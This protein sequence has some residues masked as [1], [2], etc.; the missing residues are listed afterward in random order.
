MNTQLQTTSGI[1][2]AVAESIETYN[3]LQAVRNVLAPDLNDQELQ[4]F[5]MV[6]QRSGLDPFAK[7]VYAI[8]RQGRVTFQTGIDGFRSTA[9]R[10]GEY[11]G[12]DL[13]EFGP[14]MNGHPEW[15]EVTVYREK[16]SGVRFGQAARAYWNEFYPG[17]GQGHMWKKMPR[18]QLAKCAEALAL[19]KAFPYVLSD[20]YTPE[21]MDQAGPGDSGALVQAAAQPTARERI[22]ARRAAREEA[23]ETVEPFS[24]DEFVARLAEARID[25]A[26]AAEVRQHMFP[27]KSDL[28][29]EDRHTL[30]AAVALLE[31]AEDAE[32]SED[33][34]ATIDAALE[35]AS[36]S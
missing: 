28:T 4:L 23:R 10:T 12:S 19:R 35:A 15:A 17:D 8:K 11:A 16:R 6:A 26:K 5:A 18:N 34:Q 32:F 2:P 24:K 3:R 25:P 13:P 21:E 31:P 30:W 20:I 29:D 27:D 9:E 7:Q 33:E 22:A 1:A 36:A 14:D